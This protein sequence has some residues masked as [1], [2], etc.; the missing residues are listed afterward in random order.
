MFSVG[1]VSVSYALATVGSGIGSGSA[2][3]SS[4]SSGSAAG[5]GLPKT[6]SRNISLLNNF[7]SSYPCPVPTYITG[8]L[9]IETI[10]SAAP[11]RASA[12]LLV[13]IAP[14]KVVCS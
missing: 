3:G 5:S 14:S 7:K 9:V 4:I 1:F 10:E 8:F 2:A 12:S 11:P 6:V 13:K